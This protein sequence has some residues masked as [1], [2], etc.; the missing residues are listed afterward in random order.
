MKTSNPRWLACAFALVALL[1]ATSSLAQNA[2]QDADEETAPAT[3][4]AA[5]PE[6]PLAPSPSGPVAVPSAPDAF[7]GPRPDDAATLSDRVVS[8]RIEARL[9]PEKHTIEGKQVLRW[10]NRSNQ[11]VGSVYLHLYLN[12]F[13]GTD[14]TFFSESE[15]NSF[16]FRSDVPTKEGEWGYIRLDRVQQNGKDVAQTFVQ[17]DG[18][19]ETD[20][21]VVRFD[22]PEAVPAGGELELEIDFFDQL[23][24]VV[25]R[26]GWF[27]S[28]H[29][30]AQ[31][32]PKIGVLELPGERG[33]TQPRWNV[34]QFH[35]HSEF[36]ADFGSFDVT[37]DVPSKVRVGSTGVLTGEPVVADGRTRYRY[38]QDDVHDFAW[39]ADENF[40]E[41][42]KGTW[43]FP[44]SPEVSVQVL[45]PPE[46]EKSA[47]PALQAT[48]DSLTWF[49][50]TLGPYPY[51]SVTVVIPPYNASEAG[52][53]EYP[54]F[55]TA[56]GF[57]DP[58]EGTVERV[59]L[60]F[61]TV[62][63]F[64]HGYF[65]GIV[66]SN[67]FEEPWLDEGLNE[68]WDQRMLVK[69]HPGGVRVTP[70]WMKRLFGIDPAV[71]VFDAERLGAGLADPVDP[72]GNSSW[73][74]FSS[75]SYNTVY[76]RTATMLHELERRIGSQA[77]EKAF[78]HY[79][80]QWKFRHPSS[81]DLREA[82]AEGSGQREIVEDLF[83]RHVYASGKSGAKIERFA[84]REMKPALGYEWQ[85]G[86]ATEVT[87]DIRDER[88]EAARKAWKEANPSEDG[89]EADKDKGGPY[90]YLT[91]LLL[92][93]ED[94]T[95]ETIRIDFADGSQETLTWNDDR[96]WYRAALERPSKATQVTLD[97]E[98]LRRMD[99]NLL[100]NARSIEP[101][102][103][104]S[105]RFS[106]DAAALLQSFL[107]LL[108]SL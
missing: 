85:D 94:T 24:R 81:A 73:L 79:Y 55:F 68:F 65:Y 22:L 89:E 43:T 32:F 34:H 39:M 78:K 49:S 87:E 15:R 106:A 53:M 48:L 40:A 77:L 47:A 52:G 57:H 29:L 19:P 92:R 61:V 104:A 75:S 36:Y 31:W 2:D 28:F 35:L 108:V 60:D 18:G 107:A 97:P 10:R 23:P 88:I 99:V 26:T 86:V 8:Y 100:D 27:G 80:A 3:L 72:L 66:A 82:L 45:F 70:V 69:R 33:A 105:R 71:N 14:S 93:R 20:R 30:V 12:A 16:S 46:Y 50:E 56:S 83:A 90:P 11:P 41:P 102:E 98:G 103:S 25:A 21:T 74:R 38:V 6:I 37:I 91:T 51:R 101:D 76:S 64:G 9:D 84:S 17:P 42:L 63:E 5:I 58:K 59:A 13:S 7:G 95:P 62:H 54:T 44:G 1:F 4:A 67:E 96:L